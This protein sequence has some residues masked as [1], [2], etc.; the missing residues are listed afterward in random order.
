MWTLTGRELE[1]L[2]TLRQ[3]W[4]LLYRNELLR[5]LKEGADGSDRV[6]VV[7]ACPLAKIVA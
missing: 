7:A 6:N 1:F 4:A 2:A 3:G 5:L